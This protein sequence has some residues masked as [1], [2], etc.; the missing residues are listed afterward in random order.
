MGNSAVFAYGSLV[1][2]ESIAITLGGAVD[3]IAPARLAGWRRRWSLVRDN[4]NSEKTFALEP[5]GE[6][7]PWILG[8]NIEPDPGA[9]AG[10]GPNG[11][12]LIL[13]RAQLLRLDRRELRYDRVEVSDRIELGDDRGEIDTVFTYT[14]KPDH[15]APESPEGAVILASYLEA[16]EQAFAGLGPEELERFRQ[17]TGPPP[18]TVAAGVLVRD[19]IPAGN[20]RR[21]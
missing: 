12:L 18:V 21:W 15:F 13:D 3:R 10:S 14:A 2:A 9:G 17:S 6:L 1:S 16:V 19:Q 8:L 4:E 20:P 5:G 7:P 11:A